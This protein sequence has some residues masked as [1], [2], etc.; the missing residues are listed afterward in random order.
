M[1]HIWEV[2]LSLLQFQGIFQP[3]FHRLPLYNQVDIAHT[4]IMNSVL[5]SGML[6]SKV[7]GR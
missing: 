7:A 4:I 1:L 3:L 5:T 2:Q 6:I